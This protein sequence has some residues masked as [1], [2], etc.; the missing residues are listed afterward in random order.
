MSD[1]KPTID[2]VQTF[3]GLSQTHLAQ[4]QDQTYPQSPPVGGPHAQVWLKCAVYTEELPKVNAVH[5]LEHGGVWITYLPGTKADVVSTLDQY[6]GLNT[7]YVMVSP[8]SGQ[9]SPIVV[10]AW[11]AQL[12]VT[13]PA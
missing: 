8:Y 9:D 3:S 12:K 7:E 11:G 13:D 10:T 2:G 6:A 5:S 4:G 1:P